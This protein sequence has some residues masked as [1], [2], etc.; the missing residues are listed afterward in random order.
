M[1]DAYETV[2]QRTFNQNGRRGRVRIAEVDVPIRCLPPAFAGYR[3]AHLTDLHFGP[4]YDYHAVM[5]GIALTMDLAPDLIALTGDYVSGYVDEPRLHDALSR[6]NAPDG[7]WAVLGNHDHWVKPDE[8]V[9]VLEGAGVNVLLNTNTQITRGDASLW[10]AGVDDVYFGQHDLDAALADVPDDGIAVLLAHEPDYA[11]VV[12]VDAPQVALQ[13]SGHTHGGQMRVPFWRQFLR[14]YLY[15]GKKYIY[16][17]NRVG[18]LW[19]YTSAGLGRT[20]LPRIGTRPE[21][22]LITLTSH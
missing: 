15:L 17:L 2:I 19:V 5:E 22:A 11:D 3:I 7:V 16:G 4:A 1:P 14:A 21:V 13:L 8:I 20:P 9:R 18:D 6:L 12:A 10:L